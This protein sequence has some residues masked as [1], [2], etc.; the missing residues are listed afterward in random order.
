[1]IVTLQRASW[2]GRGYPSWRLGSERERES[3][4]VTVSQSV[5]IFRAS[6]NKVRTQQCKPCGDIPSTNT[7]IGRYDNRKQNRPSACPNHNGRVIQQTLLWLWG[8]RWSP[9]GTRRG[10]WDGGAAAHELC[11]WEDLYGPDACCV[12]LTVFPPG[13]SVSARVQRVESCVSAGHRK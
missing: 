9:R 11:A 7:H 12:A 10:R 13:N 4:Y 2:D 5:N 3:C 6:K 8:C 1:V